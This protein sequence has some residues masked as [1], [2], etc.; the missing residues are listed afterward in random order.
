[1]Y[2]KMKMDRYFTPG[3]I[4]IFQVSL[5]LIIARGQGCVLHH[6]KPGDFPFFFQ[7]I[8]PV[9]TGNTCAIPEIKPEPI[10]LDEVLVVVEQYK[11][12]SRHLP[13]VDE[14]SRDV[15]KIGRA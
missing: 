4:G 15:K 6:M 12:V 11:A 10:D 7:S 8:E 2:G 1:M 5:K 14:Y 9:M 13:L 3:V